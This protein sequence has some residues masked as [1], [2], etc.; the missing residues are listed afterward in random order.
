MGNDETPMQGTR[1]SR[2]IPAAGHWE[3]WISPRPLRGVATTPCE[4]PS[5]KSSAKGA[6][7][8]AWIAAWRFSVFSEEAKSGDVGAPGSSRMRATVLKGSDGRPGSELSKPCSQLAEYQYAWL[9]G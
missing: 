6:V 8:T 9:F 1:V 7:V 5:R 3:P 2:C 4:T